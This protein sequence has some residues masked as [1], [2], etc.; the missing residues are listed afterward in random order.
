MKTF[1]RILRYLRHYKIL[2]ILWLLGSFVYAGM[3]A[4]SIYLVGPFMKTIFTITAPPITAGTLPSHSGLINKIQISF[5]MT[6]DDYIHQGSLRETLARFCF[7][8]IGAIFLKNI[9]D[10]FQGY[11][12]AY[13]EQGTVRNLRDD[14]Y[15]AYHR[16]PLRFFQKRKTGDMMS[17][18]INDCNVINDNIN[19]AIINFMK[20]SIN[21]IVLLSVMIIISWRLT[22]FSLLIAPPSLYIISKIGKKLRRRAV[23]SQSRIAAITSVLEET[24]AGI[25]I[26]KAFAMEKF[27]INRFKEA[28]KAYFKS[29][30]RLTQIQ[31]LASPV[32]EVLGVGIAVAVVWYGG[33]LVLENNRLDPELFIA[34]LLLMFVLMQSAKKLS[35]V[36]VKVQIGIAAASRVFEVIDQVND[37]T[38][39]PSPIPIK[40]LSDSIVFR[41]VWY[42][43]EPDVPVLKGINLTVG[44][45]ENIA[46]VGPSGGGKS[47][48]LDLLPRFFDPTGGMVAPG[49]PRAPEADRWDRKPTRGL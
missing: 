19:S 12:M 32:T 18:V 7:I 33:I 17:R 41:D 20:E 28:N 5:K 38:D 46:I 27:E 26:V 4:F 39:P 21:F 35:G 14:V 42:E 36:V 11:L 22:L 45:G 48:L 8:I 6:F 25:R 40:G 16:L 2:F 23:K 13:V 47:T 31:R 24:F 1:L 10:Y 44:A 43:Y 30:I 37:V 9:F 29:L 3:N 49:G 34:Y 15:A